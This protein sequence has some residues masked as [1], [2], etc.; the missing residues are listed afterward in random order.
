M[1]KTYWKH[2]R[3]K[4]IDVCYYFVEEKVETE[5]FKPVYIPSE[6]NI[7]DL[8]IK[9]LLHDATQSFAL[10]LNLWEEKD[11]QKKY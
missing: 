7:A 3:T 5:K 4:H 9:A 2:K 10:N 1:T 11:N 8:L 6:D